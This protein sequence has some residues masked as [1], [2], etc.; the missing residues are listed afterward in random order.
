M[1]S[2]RR[3]THARV[4]ALV[5]LIGWV[6]GA[7]LTPAAERTLVEAGQ[8]RA[9]IVLP[10]APS[11]AAQQAAEVLRDHLAGISGARLEILPENKL[12]N[13]KIVEG[14]VELTGP[15]APGV[16]VLVGQGSLVRQLYEVPRFQQ[17]PAKPVANA[18]SGALADALGPGGICIETFPNAIVL[19]GPDDAT[20]SDP[21]G[22]LYATTVFL[23]D[24]LGCRYLWP[25]RLGKVLSRRP[26]IVVSDVRVRYTPQI[27][28]RRIRTVGYH[29][30]LQQGL[31]R[32]GLTKD[33]YQQA[34]QKALQSDTP[35][36]DWFTWHRLG[37]TLDLRSGH[38]FG[39]CWEKYG[40]EHP[41]WFALQ[42]NGSRDQSLAGGRARLCKSNR[43]LIAQ[44]ARDKIAELRANPAA[45]SVSI[46]PN[47]GGRLTFCM[48]DHC[49]KL[50]PP[51]GRKVQLQFDDASGPRVQRKY[52]E[53]VS[54]TD[55]MVWFYN[56]IAEEVTKE[57]PDALLVADAYS[58][59]SAPPVRAKLHP[60]VVIR[61]V[62]MSYTS[63]AARKQALADWAAWS[64]AATKIY[65][66]PN[67]L[68]AGRREGT[69]VIYLHKLAED[70]RYLAGHGMIG[71]DFDSCAHNWATQG[72]NYYVLSRLLWDVQQDVEAIVADYC[73]AG[74]GPA[75]EPVRQYFVR[76]EQLTDQIAAQEL[77]ITEPY[78]PEVIAELWRLLDQ[79]QQLAASDQ[80]I[81][82][83]IGFLRKGLDYTALQAQTSRFLRQGASAERQ[84]ARQVLDEQVRLMR[85]IFAD[86]H[87]AVN[88]AYVA[89]GSGGLW[90]RL[91]WK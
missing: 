40:K 25:G 24:Q 73:R 72:L 43:E 37:G 70:L 81:V 26:T 45:K 38:A 35:Q 61:F 28:Q 63:D 6:A 8:P 52:F 91:G 65:F 87:L 33:Q 90:G 62:P 68:L 34:W 27:A 44:L 48:C 50:D 64:K 59:Y 19:F 51:E 47:D 82:G 83:R 10:D 56:A 1:N 58:A 23:E 7:A 42:P 55:R 71:T 3:P 80:E 89:W 75:A 4:L 74:F 20:P 30:R 16:L 32:L 85:E 9:V 78:T 67:L 13:V 60:N 88:V 66:R 46:C 22:T 21:W 79:A 49:K 36:P 5:G 76:I 31:D 14:R 39:Y 57:F 15:Q 18:L 54:L 86:Y 77:E 69:P 17:S 2:G 12:A 84:A 11:R 53:Y 41:E 29:D